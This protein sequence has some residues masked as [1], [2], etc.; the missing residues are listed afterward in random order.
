MEV[1]LFVKE[2]SPAMLIKTRKMRLLSAQGEVYGS[3]TPTEQKA[4]PL[5][6]GVLE[7]KTKKRRLLPN[8][9]LK[10]TLKEQQ[11]ILA[12]LNLYKLLKEHN[13]PISKLIYKDHRGYF[14]H[15]VKD[16]ILVAFGLGLFE[17][18][19]K[20]LKKALKLHSTTKPIE[21][22]DLDYLGKTFIKRKTA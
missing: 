8:N 15:L 17:K 21:R 16:D 22:I 10:T 12:A 7:S 20:K 2:R 1:V 9:Q 19:I 13:I 4:L 5:L 18:K 11:N 6:D 3:P 14:T